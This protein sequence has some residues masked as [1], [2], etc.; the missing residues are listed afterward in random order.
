MET[1]G[2]KLKLRAKSLGAAMAAGCRRNTMVLRQRLNDFKARIPRFRKLR[3][4]RADPARIIRTGGKA[5]VVYGQA[6]TGVSNSHLL[7]QRRAVA[8][9]TAPKN[10]TGGQQLDIALMLADGGPKGNADPAFDAHSL[11]IGE[12]AR[13]VWEE[14]L[15]RPAMMALAAQAKLQLIRAKRIWATVTGP[16]AA[17]VASCARLKWTVVNAMRLKTDTGIILDLTLDPPAVVEQQVRLAVVR[18]RWR[19]VE[20]VIPELA[21]NGSGRGAMMQPIWTLLKSR[22]EDMEW[23]ASLRSG[24]ASLLAG[25]QFPQTRCFA[26]GWVTHNKCTACLQ[27]IVEKAE[28]GCQRQARI[29][30]LEAEGKNAKLVVTATQAQIDSAPVGNLHHRA[31]ACKHLELDRSKHASCSDRARTKE[32]WG[33]GMAAW[34]RGLVPKPPPPPFPPSAE[35]TFHWHVEPSESL[36]SAVFYL[37]GSALDGPSDDLRRCGW[38][39]VA[40][41]DEG[42][43][44]A[45]AY[46]ATP[47]MVTDIGGAE[48][49]ALL[50]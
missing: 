33:V 13:A 46:G 21:A 2:F 18:W 9:A 32:G 28:T 4:L 26:A 25:R 31:W 20:A 30:M 35:A 19:N 5:A 43:V 6:V 44:V 8:A 47:P 12:W 14:R 36:V 49:W 7:S 27:A 16:G 38:S 15:P 29:E 48:C 45:A 50:S 17:M 22:R 34:E 41:D 23:N 1:Y 10:G 24:L 39:F 11:P 37:D 3:R 42:I 40:V